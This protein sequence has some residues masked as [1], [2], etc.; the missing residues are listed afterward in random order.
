MLGLRRPDD[1]PEDMPEQGTGPDV[2]SAVQVAESFR[3]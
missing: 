2:Q 3:N 1:L